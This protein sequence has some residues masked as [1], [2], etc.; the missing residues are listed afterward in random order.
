MRVALAL[1]AAL[2]AGC[3]GAPP[4]PDT[5]GGLIGTA[6]LAQINAEAAD[7]YVIGPN[8]LLKIIVFQVPELSL[9][10]ARVDAG[11]ALQF[12]LIGSIQAAGK[13]P[14]ALSQQIEHQLGEQYLR[15]PQVAI[16]VT[17]AA[18]QKVTVDGAVTKPGVYEM[19]GNTTLLQAIAMAQGPT[20]VAALDKIVV[21]R[22]IE[23]RRAAAVFDLQAIRAGTAPDPTILGDDIIVVDTS[24]FNSALRDVIA[25]LPGLAV[26]GYF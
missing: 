6:P 22:T 5:G 13:T 2:T 4:R 21:F 17:E 15:R 19:R 11:G 8:D 26:F 1:F 18:S 16:T 14:D 12:P 10:Q 9:D 23:G 20:R 7:Q 3:A 24:R 25:A